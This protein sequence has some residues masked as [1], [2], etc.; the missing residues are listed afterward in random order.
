ME[1]TYSTVLGL[2]VFFAVLI[3]CSCNKTEGGGSGSLEPGKTDPE[4][5]EGFLCSNVTDNNPVGI[6]NSFYPDDKVYLWLSWGNVSGS[7]KVKLYWVDPND[8]VV[9]EQDESINSKSGKA[10][11]HFF[12]DTTSSAP[13][14]RWIV[15]VHIDDHFVRSYAFWINES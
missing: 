8:D 15:E 7:H 14:G 9:S 11:T 2:T 1:K 13:T 10:I 3:F 12:I 4:I 6:D 5:I